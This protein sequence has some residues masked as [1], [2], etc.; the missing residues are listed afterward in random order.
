M[1]RPCVKVGHPWRQ[2]RHD[3]WR[4]GELNPVTHW[5][6]GGGSGFRVQGSIGF[7]GFRV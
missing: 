1:L 5:G 2:T 6:G 4:L 7:R 3:D